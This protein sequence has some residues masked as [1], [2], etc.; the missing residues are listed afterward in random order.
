VKH[1]GE[2]PL[3]V[4]DTDPGT[5]DALALYMLLVAHQKG[6]INLIGITCVNGNTSVD[7]AARNVLRVLASVNKLDE[8]CMYMVYAHEPKYI[9][10]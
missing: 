2:V 6:L 10:K 9:V 1:H 3:V 5:D 4:V 8:V 7:N